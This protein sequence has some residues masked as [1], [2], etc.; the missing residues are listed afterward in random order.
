MF[1]RTQDTLQ[2]KLFFDYR[3]VT[4]YGLPFQ[5]IH[6]KNFFLTLCGVSYNPSK[7]AYWF[8]LVPFR[9]PLLGKSH[10]LSLP[11]GTEMFQ[12]PGYATT[13]LCIQIDVLFH[14]K[15]WVPPFGNPRINVYLQ[16]PEAYRC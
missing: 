16:L 8:G 12:F 7:L 6:L 10:L 14:Y 9:S 11:P 3:A 2:R 5:A 13:I 4:F 1:R 15:Q